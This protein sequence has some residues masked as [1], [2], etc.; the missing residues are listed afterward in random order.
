MT[1][2]AYKKKYV[3]CKDDDG[4][5]IYAGDTVEVLIPWETMKPHQSKVYWSALDGAMVESHPAHKILGTGNGYRHLRD[6]LNQKNSNGMAIWENEEDTKPKSYVKG[7]CRKV[8]N[9][10]HA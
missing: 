5:T 4:K 8:K 7:F 10:Y 3:I 9:F 1:I 2:K 6:Y